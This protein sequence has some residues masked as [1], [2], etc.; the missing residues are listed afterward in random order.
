MGEAR[1]EE[2][3]CVV[4]ARGAGDE[5][6]AEGEGSGGWLSRMRNKRTNGKG[7]REKRKGEENRGQE[8]EGEERGDGGEGEGG[9]DTPPSCST[10]PPLRFLTFNVW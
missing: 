3:S 4:G 9:A 7:E 10:P 2:Q 5:K 8:T 6:S 1:A